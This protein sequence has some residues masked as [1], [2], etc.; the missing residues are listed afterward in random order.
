MK[1]VSIDPSFRS[2]AIIAGEINDD[3]KTLYPN[4]SFIIQTE[5]NKNKKV[6]AS[7]DTIQRCKQ[8]YEK[9]N[10]FISEYSPNV[11]FVETPQGSQSFKGA[12]NY[13]T[14][15]FLIATIKPAPIEV[16]PVEVK[17]QTVG[18]KTATKEEMIDWCLENYSSSILEK[19][20]D[21]SVNKS[22]S[23]H[24]ADAMAVAHC[25]ITTDQYKQL[26]GLFFN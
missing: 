13:G 19:N 22:K 11:V 9:V 2:T 1:F 15:C 5:K 7:S 23:E 20:K 25:G 4:V 24:L 16:T 21:G 8:L 10:N 3:N 6:R 17:K 18:K 14:S 26:V 12:V